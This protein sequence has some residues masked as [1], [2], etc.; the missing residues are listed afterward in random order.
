DALARAHL[1]ARADEK[2]AEAEARLAA[3]GTPKAWQTAATLRR[4]LGEPTLAVEDARKAGGDPREAEDGAGGGRRRR[5]VAPGAAEPLREGEYVRRVQVAQ[6]ALDGGQKGVVELMARQI[7][8][9]FPD[10]PAA[11]Y[12]KKALARKRR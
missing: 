3:H 11:A 2:L 4:R 9:S 5:A 6:Q 8:D 7:A 1:E 12:F 10:L